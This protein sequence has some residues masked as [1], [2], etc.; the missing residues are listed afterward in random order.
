[1]GRTA[2]VFGGLLTLEGAGFYLGT[3][4]ESWTALIPAFVGLPI[5]LLG[6]VALNPSARKH[7][8]HAASVLALLGFLAA[9]GRLISSGN[10]DFSVA[11]PLAQ[12][13]MAIL[14]GLFFLLCLKSFIDARRR[15]AEQRQ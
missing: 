2:M 15:Q 4:T 10:Y 12:L 9:A 8:M 6:A 5:L 3:G 14:C 1:M 13:V 7:A 11:A